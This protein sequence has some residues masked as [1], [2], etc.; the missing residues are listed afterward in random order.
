MT[1][2]Q[3]RILRDDY[4]DTRRRLQAPRGPRDSEDDSEDNDDDSDGGDGDEL[5]TAAV[6]TSSTTELR[7]P[8]PRG[9]LSIENAPLFTQMEWENKLA[10][11]EEN[12]AKK[13]DMLKAEFEKRLSATMNQLRTELGESKV[14]GDF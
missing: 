4:R 5:E 1:Q 13:L 10:E 14:C 7:R 3:Y 8:K 2:Q 6:A 12:M 11:V 9:T